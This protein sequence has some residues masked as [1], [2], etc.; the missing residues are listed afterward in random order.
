MDDIVSRLKT[1]MSHI[2]LPSTQFADYAN[3]PRPTI[4]QIL[5]G[6]NKK[7]S[8]ELIGKLHVAFPTLNIMWLMFG[9]GDMEIKSNIKTSESEIPPTSQENDAENS[10]YKQNN[11]QIGGIFA[12]EL[13]L[14]NSKLDEFFDEKTD[15]DTDNDNLDQLLTSSTPSFRR[16]THRAIKYIMV[17][18]S[19]NTFEVFTP[20]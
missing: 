19:D 12:D 1:Y 5:N 18:Y 10:D 17:Y 4:S 9:D 3:I 6:R 2:G 20:G 15:E 16:N 7:I 8:N 13:N 11:N 14:Q